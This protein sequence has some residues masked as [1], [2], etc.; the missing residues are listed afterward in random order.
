MA[1]ENVKIIVQEVDE[2]RPK[3]SGASSDIVYVPGFGNDFISAE[4][5]NV[6]ILCSTVDE[7]ETYFG[8][9]PYRFTSVD[10]NN[11]ALANWANVHVGDYDR[12]YIYA[13]ELINAG[14]AVLYENISLDENAHV[15]IGTFEST[16][17]TKAQNSRNV[18]YASKEY[19]T[20]PATVTFGLEGQPVYGAV[21]LIAKGRED[22]TVTVKSLSTN[23]DKFVVKDTV[24]KWENATAE[25]LE[26]VIC[27]AELE[28]GAPGSFC[29]N[30]VVGDNIGDDV[31]T[32]GNILEYFYGE[33]GLT[34]R[35]D[36]LKDKN[37]Y[38]VKYIT[39]G[40][41][42]T[43]VGKYALASKML[44]CANNRND[45]VALIDHDD[46]YGDTNEDLTL[47]GDLYTSVNDYFA[48]AAHSEFG[49]MFTPW[50]DY[51][52]VTVDDPTA[53]VQAMPASFGYLLCLANA[54]KTSPNWLA[55]AGVT[56][57]IV[58]NLRR[59]RTT[60]V[61]SNVIAENYQPKYGTEGN[62]ISINAI[63]NVKPY[64]LTIWGNRTLKPVH[65]KGT[66]A[67]NFLNTRNMISDIKKL[68]YN[69]AKSL[70]FEQDSD[71]LWLR[72]KSGV[73]PLLDQLKSGFGISD[74]KLIRSNTKY[75]GK[76]LTR[77]EMAAIIKIFPLY[78]IEYFEITVL[79]SDND[80]AI[81]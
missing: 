42:P 48:T 79:V 7:F 73:S 31:P 61:L 39:S 13:K 70:M 49:A 16:D 66:V 64:G 25:E 37:E 75:N 74:Y 71:E 11:V 56:R 40:G 21:S 77:G 38:T 8:S 10:V 50:G 35:L 53:T 18:F 76:A 23:N 45:A 78:A 28:I 14:L 2:T 5:R 30:L 52:C 22:V 55:M 59:L 12:S 26:S 57:G 1:N 43:F 44:D 54:I 36:N 67:T 19:V 62:K 4:Y 69:T 72:F 68:A 17:L 46:R 3:G 15:N 20:T 24:I 27:T 58:P 32:S 60:K 80:V 33:N 47:T 9:T 65:S 63:T 41:Y 51:T 34:T 6:P 81:S 29:L